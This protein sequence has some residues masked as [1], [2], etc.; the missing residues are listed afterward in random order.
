MTRSNG[1][2]ST[3]HEVRSSEGELLYWRRE[4]SG[5]EVR[6]EGGRY[7]AYL[8]D[9]PLGSY[10]KLTLAIIGARDHMHASSRQH[11]QNA[12]RATENSVHQTSLRGTVDA[13]VESTESVIGS[14]EV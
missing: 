6:P 3:W 10:P 12:T 1:L 9:R 14:E 8:D 13:R 7:V 4:H 2:P 11:P 5:Y